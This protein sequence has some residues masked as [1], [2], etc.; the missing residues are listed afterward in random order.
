MGPVGDIW[1]VVSNGLGLLKSGPL[2]DGGTYILEATF[3]MLDDCTENCNLVDERVYE[4][5]WVSTIGGVFKPT[6]YQVRPGWDLSFLATVSY[7]IDGEK[8]PFTFG[9]DEERG[10]GS[11]GFELSVDQAWTLDARY[12]TFFGPVAA[13]IGGLLKDRDN[14]SI[15]VKRTF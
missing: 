12:N 7:T 2:W 9:G 15:T 1:S 14:V 6:W 3:Q 11:L 5:R 13:G 10:S 8:S 4:D